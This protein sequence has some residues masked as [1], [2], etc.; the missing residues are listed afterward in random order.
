MVEV[1]SNWLEPCTSIAGVMG[2]NPVRQEFFSSFIFTTTQVV[3]MTAGF[4]IGFEVGVCL[5]LSRWL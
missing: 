4:S 1:Y 3:Y 5:T 2:W